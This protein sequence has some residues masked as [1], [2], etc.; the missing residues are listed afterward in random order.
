MKTKNND[1][2]SYGSSM[3]SFL[4]NRHTLSIVAVPNYISTKSVGGFPF[5]LEPIIQGLFEVRQRQISYDITY[6]W[7]PK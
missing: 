1:L 5:L 6:M 2:G 3:F 4:K 7:N